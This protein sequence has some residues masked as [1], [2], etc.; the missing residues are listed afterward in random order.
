MDNDMRAALQSFCSQNKD[1]YNKISSSKLLAACG[2]QSTTQAASSG[3]RK[4]P[5]A[6]RLTDDQLVAS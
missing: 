3:T 4:V 2:L 5:P 1:S 6:R